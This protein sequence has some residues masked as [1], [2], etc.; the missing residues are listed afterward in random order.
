MNKHCSVHPAGF[1]G[2]PISLAFR[3]VG[4]ILGCPVGS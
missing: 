4:G 1:K 3:G 2:G